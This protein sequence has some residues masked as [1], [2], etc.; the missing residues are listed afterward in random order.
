MG[1]VGLGLDLC[2]QVYP[3]CSLTLGSRQVSATFDQPWNMPY[4]E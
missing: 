3:V 1:G 4:P 2:R